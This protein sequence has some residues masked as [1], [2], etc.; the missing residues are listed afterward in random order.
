MF[1][2]IDCNL[3]KIL[4]THL[5]TLNVD[6]PSINKSLLE[7]LL[8]MLSMQSYSCEL[9]VSKARTKFITIV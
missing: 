7:N 6:L 4:L 1:Q 2:F 9:I 3:F 8:M 5:A